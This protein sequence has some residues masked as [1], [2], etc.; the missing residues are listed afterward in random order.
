MDK[1]QLTRP[2]MCSVVALGAPILLYSASRLPFARLDLNFLI[3]AV[4]VAVGSRVAVPIPRVSGRITVSDTFV[5]L[6]MLLYGGEAAVVLAAV[7]GVCST[8]WISKRA[9]TIV[10]NAAVLACSAFITVL[11]LRLGFGSI[12][13]L[14]QDG[15]SA[16]LLAAIC[17]MA[18]T[19]YLSNTVL[20]AVEKSF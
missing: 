2:Y 7:E 8:L 20:I 6:S 17:V 19:Q 5:F 18:M 4:M 11:A 14:A 13:A 3:L 1:Q 15:Y 16:N 10:F 12:V 9:L